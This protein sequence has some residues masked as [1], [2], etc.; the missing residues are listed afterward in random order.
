MPVVKKS[1]A[2][3]SARKS[4]PFTVSRKCFSIESVGSR[5]PRA[6]LMPP[7]AAPVCERVGYTLLSTPTRRL[8][9][10]LAWSAA[11]MPA[12]PAPTITTSYSS[13]G[14]PSLFNISHVSRGSHSTLKTLHVQAFAGQMTR[15][16]TLGTPAGFEQNVSDSAALY[17][18]ENRAGENR[19][20]QNVQNR[21][22]RRSGLKIAGPSGR[23]ALVLTLYGQTW[24]RRG[25]L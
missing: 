4:L 24:R 23:Q 2:S 25:S 9:S 11:L 3:W 12:P 18:S 17:R 20:E 1:T 16:S 15:R 21:A 8:P 10:R 6:A 14:V 5:K 22:P 13:T 7:C 19:N